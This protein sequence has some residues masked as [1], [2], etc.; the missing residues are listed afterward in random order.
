[1]KKVDLSLIAEVIGVSLFAVGVA[2]ISMPAAF[3]SVGAFLVWVTEK[4]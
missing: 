3:I 2:M 1:M 4:N